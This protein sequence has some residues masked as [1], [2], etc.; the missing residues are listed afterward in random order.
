MSIMQ[1]ADPLFT[2]FEQKLLSFEDEGMDRQSF[3]RGVVEEYVSY[4]RKL[5]IAIPAHLEKH[6]VEELMQQVTAMLV[7]KMYGC[8][9]IKD[10]ADGVPESRKKRVKRA[11]TR[12]RKTA[13]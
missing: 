2:I 1:E 8:L 9:T 7:K 3:V 12:L 11:Y 4:L 10:F 6:V 13:R 5:N